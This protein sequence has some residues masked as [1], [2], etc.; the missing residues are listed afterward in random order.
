MAD[1]ARV[2][3]WADALIRLHLD[4]SWTFAFDN[5]RTRAG[6]CNYTRKRISV[7]RHIATLSDDDAIHQVLLHEV[8]HA[9]AGQKAGHGAKWRAVAAEL[10]YEGGRTHDGPVPTELAPWVG[11]CPNGHVAYRYRR[12]TRPNSCGVCSRR[13][14]PAYRIEWAKR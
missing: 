3:T 1:L 7:S 14:D 12:P 13:F 6:L 5:A 2:R 4:P 11:T 10:G 8:A 9:I